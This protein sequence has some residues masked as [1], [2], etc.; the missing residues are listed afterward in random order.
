MKTFSP[1]PYQHRAIEH[2]LEHPRC[3]LW[4]EP[5][6]GKT[7]VGLTVIDLLQ[8]LDAEPALVLGPK[9]VAATGW[10]EEA[11]KWKHLDHLEV[12][13]IVGERDVRKAALRNRN[14]SIFTINYENLPWLIKELDGR[15]PFGTVIADESTRLKSFRLRQ[16]GARAAAI[17]RVAHTRVTRWINLTGTPSTDGLTG[18]WGQTWFLDKGKRLGY[19]FSG[20]EQR[21][22]RRGHGDYANLELLPYAEQEIHGA[23]RDICFALKAADYL[24]LPPLVSNVIE[25]ELP[26]NA[27]RLYRDMEREMFA[28]IA[29]HGVEA[30]NAA[31]RTIKCLQLAN[32]A[33]YIGEPDDPART[34][35][36]VHTAKLEALEDLIDELDGNPLLV[37]Y[38]FKSD[39]E[40]LLKAFP[41]AADLATDEGMARFKA[42]AAPLGLGHPK[43][44]GHGVDGLQ[45]R[46]HNVAFFGHWWSTEERLQM[47]ERVGPTRQ[48]QAERNKPVIVHDLVARR[49]VDELVLAKHTTNRSMQD[50]LMAAMKEAA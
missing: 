34:W 8:A 19:T 33:A 1:R 17:G 46:C 43:S 39:H 14:A 2:L 23:L 10:S 44:M 9:R 27:R 28:L 47:I 31:A 38:Q 20:F 50:L 30:F 13:P 15:W 24:D 21:W 26:P 48:V 18:L 25:V 41:K 5:G 49:T 6:L 45:N 32:G 40:R 16:G 36:E 3:A 29:G 7:V 42:G 35:V 22:Y 37:G 4:A 11:A 12:Q